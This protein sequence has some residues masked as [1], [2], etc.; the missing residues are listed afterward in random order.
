MKH[1]GHLTVQQHFSPRSSWTRHKLRIKYTDGA[2]GLWRS[3]KHFRLV[4]WN[5]VCISICVYNINLLLLLY[6]DLQLDISLY[7]IKLNL[8][9]LLSVMNMKEWDLNIFPLTT[10]INRRRNKEHLITFWTRLSVLISKSK[11]PSCK[12]R[13]TLYLSRSPENTTKQHLLDLCSNYCCGN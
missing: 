9:L 10:I 4:S 13:L 3:M 11:M 8:V 6:K 1:T 2:D 12:F 7:R 5:E